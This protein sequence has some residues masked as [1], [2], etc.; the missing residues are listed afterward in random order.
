[1]NQMT[2][3]GPQCREV[4]VELSW[5]ND[6]AVG[7]GLE[8]A[9]ASSKLGASFGEIDFING[10]IDLLEEELLWEV[11]DDPHGQAGV[12]LLCETCNWELS[13]WTSC[14][15]VL[16]RYWSSPSP[17]LFVS[18]GLEL[19]MLAWDCVGLLISSICN[20]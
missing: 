4:G 3:I 5:Y 12:A 20:V 8:R 17:P 1:M 13:L 18:H 10:I 9:S 7:V 16:V 14:E 15:L 11:G 6:L 2:L 19:D